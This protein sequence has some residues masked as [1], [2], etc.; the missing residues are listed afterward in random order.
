MEDLAYPSLLGPTL[1]FVAITLAVAAG[2]FLSWL[3]RKIVLRLNRR[4]TGLREASRVA[5]LPL[6]LALCLTGVRIALALTT[7]DGGWRSTA[8]HV[9]LIA[10]IGS[11]A[12]LAVTVLL[13]IEALM[14]THYSVDVA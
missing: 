7:D 1:P 5:R 8:D 9:L 14:L 2:L 12:W 11:I 3:L 10:L 13:V 6:R 4:M